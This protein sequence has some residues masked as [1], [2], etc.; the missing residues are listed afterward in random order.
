MIPLRIDK[1]CFNISSAVEYLTQR[2][3]E[4]ENAEKDPK[5][6]GKESYGRKD[7]ENL[8]YLT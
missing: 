1:L 5:P 2:R 3:R 4:A 8:F 6:G 7:L